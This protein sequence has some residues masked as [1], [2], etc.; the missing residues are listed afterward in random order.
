MTADPA[1]A[2]PGKIIEAEDLSEIEQFLDGDGIAAVALSPGVIENGKT[3]HVEEGTFYAGPAD[4]IQGE[5]WHMNQQDTQ[6]LLQTFPDELPA[7]FGPEDRND[8]D[9]YIGNRSGHPYEVKLDEELPSYPEWPP[10]VHNV[11]EDYA[12]LNGN[13]TIGLPGPDFPEDPA[14]AARTLNGID[15]PSRKNVAENHAGL[16][17]YI[18][19]SQPFNVPAGVPHYVE[20]ADESVS[21]IV[22]RGDEEK[23]VYK[24]VPRRG[25]V[26]D[27]A[28]EGELWEENLLI[29][30][31]NPTE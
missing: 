13:I 27:K 28:Y 9:F 2:Q 30:G 1:E 18:E 5:Y 25:G 15:D 20:S 29:N 14:E 6:Q 24:A 26:W 22:A 4:R 17:S 12:P 3:N 19:T 11:N 7:V 31:Y 16:F 10:H 21:M 8:G 23:D